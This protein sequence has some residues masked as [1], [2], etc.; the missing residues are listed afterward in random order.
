MLFLVEAFVRRMESR[1][2]KFF[3]WPFHPYDVIGSE[4]V[5]HDILGG[6]PPRGNLPLVEVSLW[7]VDSFLIVYEMHRA[8]V[9]EAD[10]SGECVE[11][12]Y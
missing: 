3:G 2:A 6:L 7:T 1:E 5:G 10:D 12:M 9:A 11:M 4:D 8:G